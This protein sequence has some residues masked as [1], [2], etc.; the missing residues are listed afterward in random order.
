M[1]VPV[2]SF[3]MIRVAVTMVLVVVVVAV[4]VEDLSMVIA[5]A[6]VGGRDVTVHDASGARGPVRHPL[7]H[8]L[9]Q[10]KISDMPPHQFVLRSGV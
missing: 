10:S 6:V 1:A 8:P 9:P 5:V 4:V 7:G 3:L 2:S